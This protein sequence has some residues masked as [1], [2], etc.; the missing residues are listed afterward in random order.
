MHHGPEDIIR[1][2]QPVHDVLIPD[3][4]IFLL[5]SRSE[6]YACTVLKSVLPNVLLNEVEVLFQQVLQVA[7]KQEVRLVYAN[8]DGY[9]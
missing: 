4:Q 1:V 3:V 9:T 8:Q 7:I 2:V 6:D 5:R